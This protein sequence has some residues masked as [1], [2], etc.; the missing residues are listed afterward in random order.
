MEGGYR[1]FW[2]IGPDMCVP[3]AYVSM[4]DEKF[5]VQCKEETAKFRR[6]WKKKGMYV[7]V[8]VCL[9]ISMTIYM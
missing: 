5:T 3:R 7:C 9:H 4:W 1:Q 8:Y 6:S 2:K